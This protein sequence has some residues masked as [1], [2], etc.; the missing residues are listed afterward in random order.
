[1]NR[2]MKGIGWRSFGSTL[3][4]FGLIVISRQDS[5]PGGWFWT[6]LM[7]TLMLVGAPCCFYVGM[8]V[9]LEM[10]VRTRLVADGISCYIVVHAGMLHSTLNRGPR[11]AVVSIALFFF[12]ALCGVTVLKGAQRP[13]LRFS[14]RFTAG[15]LCFF[16]VTFVGRLFFVIRPVAAGH[17]FQS[18][19]ILFAT[20]H[21]SPVFAYLWTDATFLIINQRQTA[22]IAHRF[23]AQMESEAAL[24]H[25][26]MQAESARQRQLIARDL[27]DGI[28]GITANPVLLATLG[29]C[30]AASRNCAGPSGPASGPARSCASSF[31]SRSNNRTRRF[32][33]PTHTPTPHC[34]SFSPDL[35]RRPPI[36][37]PTP[38]SRSW[39]RV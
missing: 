34:D 6:L 2:E 9:F 18:S 39:H 22:E 25:S 29:R 27:H 7:P 15:V 12:C 36:K 4:A 33:L 35:K 38:H 19:G 31:L 21:A 30:G 14:M 17:I 3:H 8:C 24:E 13:E 20:F 28:G 32:S 5:I 26:R 11:D 16:C 10:P 1:M 23:Q 37:Q